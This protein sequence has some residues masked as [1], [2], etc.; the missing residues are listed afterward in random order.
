MDKYTF[1][2]TFVQSSNLQSV[3]ERRPNARKIAEFTGHRE[4]IYALATME[5]GAGIYSAGGD[6]LVVGWMKDRNPESTGTVAA[7]V[8][9]S[10][11]ALCSISTRPVL[12]AGQNQYG[13]HRIDLKTYE[14]ASVATGKAA[15][16]TLAEGASNGLVYAGLSTGELIGLDYETL[17]IRNR[18]QLSNTSIRAV[19]VH[20]GG[21]EIAVGSSDHHIR[22][23]R[24]DE[25]E[26]VLQYHW[27]GH[28]NS[29]FSLTYSPD[30]RSLLSAGRDARVMRWDAA[31]AYRSVGSVNAHLHTIHQASYSPDGKHFLTCSMDKTIKI[32]SSDDLRL[33][34]VIDRGRHGGHSSSVNRLTW[35]DDFHFAS[36]GDDRR[37]ILWQLHLDE[38]SL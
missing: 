1:R 22:I 27:Q 9:G 31:D 34:R 33:L 6:G 5:G 35:L 21:H 20:P 15:I 11:Y 7:K 37:V 3:N 19:A 16:F 13:I 24:T 32:W 4:S 29:V 36:A 2:R 12:L 10:V 18:I 25:T 26:P 8:P 14:S 30:G 28:V 38:N 17:E 23:Y